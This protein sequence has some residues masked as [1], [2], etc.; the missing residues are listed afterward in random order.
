M[1]IIHGSKTNEK[2][3]LI[4]TASFLLVA[5]TCILVNYSV[6]RS[7]NWSLLPV[8]ALFVLWATILTLLF[9]KKYKSVGSFA[10]LAITVIPYLFLIQSQTSAKGWVID[11][12][13]PITLLALFALGVSLIGFRF[14]KTT[15]FYPIALTIFLFGVM[16]NYGIGIILSRYLNG[17]NIDDISRVSTMSISALTTIMLVIVGYFKSD[18]TNEQDFNLQ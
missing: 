10:G 13:I 6:N 11:L 8:G 18:K 16:V 14:M 3:I 5:L 12:A 17:N 4:F 9:I 1:A 15:K 7:I 2:P